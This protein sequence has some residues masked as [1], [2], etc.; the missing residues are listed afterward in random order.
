MSVSYYAVINVP[1]RVHYHLEC[2]GTNGFNMICLLLSNV[3][4]NGM[5]NV[6]N[7]MLYV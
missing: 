2:W 7:I 3:W 1:C 6:V 4:I 5:Y